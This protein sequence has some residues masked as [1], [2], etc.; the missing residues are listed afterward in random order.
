MAK[1][2][3]IQ[4]GTCRSREACDA[5]PYCL[6]RPKGSVVW[7]LHSEDKGR[8]GCEDVWAPPADGRCPY[9]VT[10]A[11][12][13]KKREALLVRRVAKG[14]VTLDAALTA[15]E[16]LGLELDAKTKT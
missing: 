7:P 16:G 1:K 13:R 9:G 14:R 5:C 11:E 2:P 3:W 10:W 15:A 12:G 6:K 4:T 8:V